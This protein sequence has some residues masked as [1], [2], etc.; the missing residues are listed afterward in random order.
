[1]GHG[2]LVPAACHCTTG[3]RI[4]RARWDRHSDELRGTGSVPPCGGPGPPHA[5]GSRCPRPRWAR[6]PTRWRQSPAPPTRLRGSATAGR[7]VG[8]W[9]SWEG[10][11]WG[12]RSS[13]AT[14][15][16]D[17]TP[18]PCPGLPAWIFCPSPR[19]GVSVARNMLR[20]SGSS[21]YPQGNGVSERCG[22][23]LF[24]G[25]VTVLRAICETRCR[26]RT[27]LPREIAVAA[28]LRRLRPSKRIVAS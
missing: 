20:D 1:M 11:L 21:T 8:P 16:L 26:V 13:H 18:Q 24:V 19:I 15:P 6:C 2:P 23:V 17:L 14:Y 7:S 25:E 4:G 10:G 22:V 9:P 28:R 27:S 5:P 3:H 12:S